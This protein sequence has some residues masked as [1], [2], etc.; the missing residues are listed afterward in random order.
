MAVFERMYRAAADGRDSVPWDR[1][2]PHPLLEEW[3]RDVDGAGRR[4]LVVGSGLGADAELVAERGFDVVG[5]DASVTAITMARSRFPDT[6]VDYRVANLLDLPAQWR[7][8]FDLVVES[9]TVQSMPPAYH[10]RATASI[11]STV[12]P[13]GTL[14]V[15]A[16]ARD[17][18]GNPPDGPPWPLTRLEVEA[19]ASEGLEPERIELVRA[20]GTAARWRAQLRR[21]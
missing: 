21:T 14:L 15:I 11:V 10:V 3:A 4:A 13:G 7:A 19:F 1:G 8:A 17:E 9:L 20:P 6:V 12:A 2:G 16:T 18:A 5:F